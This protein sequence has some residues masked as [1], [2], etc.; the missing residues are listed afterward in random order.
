MRVRTFLR[1]AR[2]FELFLAALTYFLGAG[3][4]RYLGRDL[5][6]LPLWAGLAWVLL[7]QF[8]VHLLAAYFRPLTEPLI[9]GETR[10]ARVRMRLV[11][12][13]LAVAALGVAAVLTVLLLHAGVLAPSVLFL[14]LLALVALLAYAVPPVRLVDRG[15]GELTLA[16]LLA[17]LVPAIAF[18]LQAG[19]FHRL[20][21]MVTFPLTTLALAF[22]LASDFPTFATD[23]KFDRHT[24]L[25]R[26]GWQRAVPLHHLLL[27]IAYLLFA[28]APLLKFPWALIWP[29]FLTA[30]LAAYQVFMLR[31][32]ALGA[33]PVWRLLL[34]NGAAI[35]GLTAYSLAL[36][37]WIR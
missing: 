27:L 22:F 23:L 34:I 37:F 7:L 8:A 35:F 11:L 13:Q 17:D 14:L 2:P 31:N 5:R 36:T 33:K 16:I 19:E 32:I 18:L 12:L 20:L 15:F 1:L 25:T 10:R 9:E 26:L 21:A 28:A 29:A 4:A 30:P 24:M 3:A 6:L